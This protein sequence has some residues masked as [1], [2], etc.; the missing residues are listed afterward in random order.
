MF[1]DLWIHSFGG[2]AGYRWKLEWDASD[3]DIELGGTTNAATIPLPTPTGRI[4]ADPD[5]DERYAEIEVWKVF[6]DGEEAPR[7]ATFWLAWNPGSG[8]WSVVGARY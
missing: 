3:P 4:D 7:P 6:G 1:D 8:S 5:E 2:P